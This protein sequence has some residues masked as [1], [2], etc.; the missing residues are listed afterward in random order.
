MIDA[1]FDVRHPEAAKSGWLRLSIRASQS[2]SL[3][4]K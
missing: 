3:S 2:L 1:I 4:R